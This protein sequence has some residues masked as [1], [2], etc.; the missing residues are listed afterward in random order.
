MQNRNS[1]WKKQ[2]KH[3]ITKIYIF[4]GN[5]K[6]EINK[7][8]ELQMNYNTSKYKAIKRYC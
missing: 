5:I 3:L 7:L 1:K 8:Y 4:F 2:L 6:E